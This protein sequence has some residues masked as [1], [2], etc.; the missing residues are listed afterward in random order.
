M[1]PSSRAYL[2]NYV[3][4][5]FIIINEMDPTGYD[6][7]SSARKADALPLNYGPNLSI[8]MDKLELI[9]DPIGYAPTSPAR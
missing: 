2:M 5:L 1:G 7:V 3:P 8:F 6:P 4:I 9:L